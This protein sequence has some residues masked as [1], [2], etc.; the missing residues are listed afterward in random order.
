M[1]R[2]LLC[3]VLV[4]MQILV[5]V[6]DAFA[7][8]SNDITAESV[9]NNTNK[10]EN[11]VKEL[12]EIGIITF[13][14]QGEELITRG[15]FADLLV[16]FSGIDPE[17]L[18]EPSQLFFDVPVTHEYFQ[19]IAFCTRQ[20]YMVGYGDGIFQPN[21]MITPEEAIK[22]IIKALGYDY[23]AVPYGNNSAAYISVAKEIGM[24]KGIELPYGE[25]M[26]QEEAAKLL[27]NVLEIPLVTVTGVSEKDYKYSIDPKKTAL[28][29][30]HK[31]A[32]TTGALAATD[33][34]GI[35]GF[36]A[37]A[38]GRCVV[39]GGIFNFT[40]PL[41]RTYIGREVD[42]LYSIDE[43]SLNDVII[44]QLKD[45]N[46]GV[47]ISEEDFVSFTAGKF[48][49]MKDDD[50][51]RSYNVS[52]NFEFIYNG[53]S[54]RYNESLIEDA[55]YGYFELY[56]SKG[57]NNYDVVVFN[58]YKT[59]V[60]EMVSPNNEVIHGT[61]SLDK[62]INY[63][64]TDY[65]SV[66]VDDKGRAMDPSNISKH[67][68]I[69]YYKNGDYI[70][71][72]VKRHTIS[73]VINEIND[74]ESEISIDG[75]VYGL[76]G[77]KKS[78]YS[79][80]KTSYQ[81][82][83]YLDIFLNI[84]GMDLTNPNKLDNIYIP[85]K[86][87]K[88]VEAG[89]EIPGLKVYDLSEKAFKGIFFAKKVVINNT[90]TDPVADYDFIVNILFDGVNVRPVI[91]TINSE[92]KIRMI[93]T[94]KAASAYSDNQDG[95][96]TAIDN[97][98]LYY[99]KSIAG[100]SNGAVYANAYTRYFILPDAAE[101]TT[102]DEMEF[103]EGVAPTDNMKRTV[104]VY[105]DSKNN[106]YAKLVIYKKADYY[107]LPSR[108]GYA[109]IKKI[110]ETV[111]EDGEKFKKIY[112]EC[113]GV[114][115][116]LLSDN[117]DLKDM[118]TPAAN[119]WYYKDDIYVK[120]LGVGDIISYTADDRG[121]LQKFNCVWKA[122]TGS[123]KSTYQNFAADSRVVYSE[124]LGI[125]NEFIKIKSDVLSATKVGNEGLASSTTSFGVVEYIKHDTLESVTVIGANG[126]S[127][128]AAL[129][130][131]SIGDKVV[132]NMQSSKLKRIFIIK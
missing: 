101:I 122:D 93:E 102:A 10:F 74:D 34:T 62:I 97:T 125:D 71:A 66:F 23:K 36:E 98:S 104:S 132:I 27:H 3:S 110:A 38:Y 86:A 130:D 48:R 82:D 75:T 45:K 28:S 63:D 115:Y 127:F 33:I 124:I 108:P 15:G 67:D 44:L 88:K 60:V 118:F 131:L 18:S 106:P 103:F 16:R 77:D 5:F 128:T 46:H 54:A 50:K 126:N 7:A 80:F 68:V 26:F 9:L 99:V 13:D 64:S 43:A 109:V 129:S 105:A 72:M 85:I 100:F 40:D 8:E 95:F 20:G 55:E 81:V 73:G 53:K 116:T 65:I 1:M 56:S 90:E 119:T 6:P 11:E 42:V 21:K 47:M 17:T 51:V 29:V 92:N 61:T 114:E 89:E 79:A 12:K 57:D 32:R 4:L 24:L 19:S 87:Y 37:M 76:S 52:M 107:G 70:F 14:L 84:A 94:P 22:P 112:C 25:G 49:Y 39:N 69:T 120:D 123:L 58:D 83:A 78:L 41:V 91:L 113:D 121:V 59:T 96:T 117:P 30:Y 31:M 2:K 35:F 111:N